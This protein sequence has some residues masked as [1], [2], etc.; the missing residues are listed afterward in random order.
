MDDPRCTDRI[1]GC[2]V[3]GAI[4]DA[5]GA[6][7]EGQTP[8]IEI[9]RSLGWML[10]DDTQLT[11]ATC[12]A[13]VETG[14]ADPASIAARMATWFR[15]GRINGIGAA[16]YKAL[17]ELTAGGHWALVGSR[18]ERAA[19]N[20]AAM[21]IAPLAFHLNPVLPEHRQR[22]RDISRITHHHE[23]AYCGALAVVVAVRTAWLETSPLGGDLL[24]LV[25]SALPDSLVRDRLREL[26]VVAGAMTLAEIAARYGASGYVVESVPM[27]VAAAA[28]LEEVGFQPLMESIVSWGG[29]ADTI[30]SIAGQIAGCRLGFAA[31]PVTMLAQLPERESVV[32]IAE[33]FARSVR[34][35]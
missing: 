9:D 27:A 30:A 15:A 6:V 4:G 14:Q 1:L 23:E 32:E 35:T 17:S 29:D 19:G 24:A 26:S 11:L 20:G 10:T 33:H 3:G 22:I 25:A 5:F 12:E 16:T 18:G 21:R 2:F 13:I 7:Y 8:P 31:L 28:R 34:P